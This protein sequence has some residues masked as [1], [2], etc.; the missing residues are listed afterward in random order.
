MQK[1][2]AIVVL[3]A[4]GYGS[5]WA[6]DRNYLDSLL[7]RL[8]FLQIKTVSISVT[9]P[10]SKKRVLKWLPKLKGKNLLV[11]KPRE[12]L[13]KLETKPW[14]KAVVIKK[15]FPS[16]ISLN[17][18]AKKARAILSRRGK[19]KFLDSFGEIIAPVT[20]QSLRAFDLPVITLSVNSTASGWNPHMSIRL[21]DQLSTRLGHW[22][23]SE[24]LLDYYPMFHVFLSHP[25]VEVR[26]S[27][28]NWE[29]QLSALNQILTHPPSLT[30]QMRVINLVHS[31]KAIVS[32]AVS[33]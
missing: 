16:R 29:S 2:Y 27:R 11:L 19:L 22:E 12:I 14:V 15:H 30:N 26:F 9:K 24:M 8:S 21:L 7:N 25:P 10:L 23:V 32:D 6:Y 31:K 3:S 5:H 17:I 28:E 18:K 20:G 33:N 1:L 13:E 4:L